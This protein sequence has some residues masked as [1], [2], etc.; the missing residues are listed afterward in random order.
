MNRAKLVLEGV[1]ARLLGTVLNN[2]D[3]ESQYGYYSRYYRYHYYY[4][5]YYSPESG[6]KKKRRGARA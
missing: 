2:F 3:F 5:Y 1:K 4:Y 6:E